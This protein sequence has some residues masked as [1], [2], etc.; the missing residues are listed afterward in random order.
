LFIY[1]FDRKTYGIHADMTWLPY[2][3]VK[4]QSTQI[5]KSNKKIEMVVVIFI[6]LAHEKLIKFLKKI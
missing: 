4:I 2:G 1:A 3:Y 6:Y 5:A